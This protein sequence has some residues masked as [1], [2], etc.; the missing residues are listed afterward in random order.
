MNR[1]FSSSPI[2]LYQGIAV[3]RIIIGMLLIYHGIEIFNPE[4]MNG[5]LENGMFTGSM[6][7]FLVYSG[8]AS[9]LTVGILFLLGFLTRVAAVMMMGTFSYITFIVG[10]VRFWYEEQHPFMF[11]LFGLLFFFTGPG[12]WNIDRNIFKRKE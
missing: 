8:K 1:F 12:D 11:A 7:K 9:E 6:A 2:L 5:Y 3:V 4:L 10:Q